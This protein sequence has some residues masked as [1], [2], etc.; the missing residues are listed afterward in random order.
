MAKI[1]ADRDLTISVIAHAGDGNTHPL[2]VYDPSDAAM[3]ERAHPRSARSWTWPSRSAGPSPVSTAWAGSKKPWLAGQ[4][5]PEAI[6]LN[7]RIKAALD[8]E[9][10][11]N[12]GAVI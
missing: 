9:N 1:A 11:L 7:R 2:I 3:T 8:P 10:I 5:G 4:L 12:P 6:E